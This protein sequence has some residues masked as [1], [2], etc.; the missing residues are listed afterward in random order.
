VNQK[1]AVSQFMV[2][3]KDFPMLAKKRRCFE[4]KTIWL[5]IL[6]SERKPLPFL[7]RHGGAPG[8]ARP[9]RLNLKPY[10]RVSENPMIILL[11]KL[12]LNKGSETRNQIGVA[13]D[14]ARGGSRTK[15]K[16]REFVEKRLGTPVSAE[17]ARKTPG[18]CGGGPKSGHPEG[19]S[20]RACRSSGGKARVENQ[21][22][23]SRATASKCGGSK[24]N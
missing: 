19:T 16:M 7:G 17:D 4:M 2:D 5:A 1:A 23:R 18:N 15:R 12:T 10:E 14:L 3:W 20:G 22:M 8:R 11:M 9:Q 21:G 6:S 13:G 24:E